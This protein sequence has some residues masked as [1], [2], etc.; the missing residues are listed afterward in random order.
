[1]SEPDR[2]VM[3]DLLNPDGGGQ[4]K[5]Y[6]TDNPAEPPQMTLARLLAAQERLLDQYS[7]Q[8]KEARATLTAAAAQLDEMRF[9]SSS[10][11]QT[12]VLQ[13]TAGISSALGEAISLARSEIVV[14]NPAVALP[15]DCRT[16]QLRLGQRFL[17]CDV[18]VRSLHLATIL[19]IPK[20][21]RYLRDLTGDGT[22]IRISPVLPIKMAVVDGMVA[23][24]A[25]P[26]LT[27]NDTVLRIEDASV[28]EILMRLFDHFWI[29][30]SMPLDAA[31]ED[32]T[33]HQ[34][35]LRDQGGCAELT[36]RELATLRYMAGG[37][38]DEAIAR[39]LGVSPRTLRR[40]VAGML[41]RLG[42][43]SRFQAG[44]EA[45]ARGWLV[46]EE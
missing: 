29:H 13:G 3:C 30:E 36:S 5:N 25:S 46:P 38:K 33:A 31:I 7:L 8:I 28:I 37:L 32:R 11:M 9:S 15:S 40:L 24:T 2:A 10:G 35:K 12:S 44:V 42:S 16:G 1:M 18:P 41:D 23:F 39:E 20:V 22:K 43:E 6:I 21:V 19:G 34:K 26:R 14:M 27:Q 45:M 17:E 4:E